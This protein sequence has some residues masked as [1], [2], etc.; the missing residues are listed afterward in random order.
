MCRNWIS[1]FKLFLPLDV[2]KL[3]ETEMPK[4]TALLLIPGTKNFKKSKSPQTRS[5]TLMYIS[6]N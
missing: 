3:K 6:V 4:G 5:V 1:S 2:A